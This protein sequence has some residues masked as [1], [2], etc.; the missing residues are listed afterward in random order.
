VALLER[1]REGILNH[2]ER[3]I[4]TGKLEGINNTI[5]VIKR[6]GS[7]YHDDRYFALKV[8]QAFHRNYSNWS[9]ENP[10]FT[11]ATSRQTA[12]VM[13]SSISSAQRLAGRP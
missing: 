5:E 2:C 12:A 9:G 3:P 11:F 8:K 7:G 10:Y 6:D 13:R 4:H 1:H